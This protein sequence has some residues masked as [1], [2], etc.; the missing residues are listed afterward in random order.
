LGWCRSADFLGKKLFVGTWRV[1]ACQT[2]SL[3]RLLLKKV[4][5][6][7]LPTAT[8][9]NALMES[10]IERGTGFAECMSK[11]AWEHFSGRPWSAL[12]NEEQ[13]TLLSAANQSPYA[14]LRGIFQSTPLISARGGA[15]LTVES[16]GYSFANDVNPILERSCSGGACHDAA[17]TLGVQYRLIRDQAAFRKVPIA[18]LQDS[19]MPPASSNKTLADSEQAILVDFLKQP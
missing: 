18:R 8:G 17:S 16:S 5:R 14:L 11:R 1:F 6:F 15:G 10:Y 4:V 12:S 19:S 2:A 9:P 3:Q 7:G 13:T